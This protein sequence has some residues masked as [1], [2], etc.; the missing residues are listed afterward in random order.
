MRP[1]ADTILE[2]CRTLARFTETPGRIHRTFLSPPMRDVHRTLD[3]WVEPLAAESRVDAIGNWRALVRGRDARRRLVIGSHLDT[4]PDA[5]AFDGILGVVLGIA[6][7][8]SLT[9]ELPFDLELIGFS[10]EEGV[11]FGQPFFGSLAFAGRFP[12]A[13]L[14]VPD[15]QG[16]TVEE[17]IRAYGL[18]P[19]GI[20]E[21]VYHPASFGFFEMHIEQG[22]VLEQEGRAVAAVAGIAGQT[23][24]RVH[25]TGQANHAGTTPM[26]LRRD[27][28][29][30]AAEWI[31][32]VERIGQ[33][34]PGLVATVG[35]L[36]AEPGAGNVIAG[37]AR[38]TLDVR[39]GDD[40]ARLAAVRTIEA[41]AQ[42]IANVRG[43]GCQIETLLDQ[44]AVPCHAGLTATLQQALSAEKHSAETII[45][46]AG[47]DTMI[48]APHLAATMLFLRSPGGISH[49]PDESVLPDDVDAAL[50]V[51]RRFILELENSP[52]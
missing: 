6:L 34:T 48:I 23:R 32:F 51:A 2:R 50:A 25:F 29:A 19:A 13:T 52:L 33:S 42:R 22:P 17:A 4:V 47:H 41:A 7:A 39:H 45:S 31:G 26:R 43:I 21:A 5:G 12:D 16:V 28:L 38:A 30:A 40:T 20:P 11:R 10:E 14:A 18:D 35:R 3:A 37:Y 27:A 15:A 46:G 44:P 1:A 8:E 36:D 24:R 49:H 9:G